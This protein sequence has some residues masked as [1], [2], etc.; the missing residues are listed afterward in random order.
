M[1]DPDEADRDDVLI[2]RQ[3]GGEGRLPRRLRAEVTPGAKHRA[4]RVDWKGKLGNP[5][6]SSDLVEPEREFGDNAE[7][8]A[9]AT[10]SPVKIGVLGLA[11]TDDVA[12]RRDHLECHNVVAGKSVLSGQPPHAAAEGEATDS[13]M[14]NVPGRRC[15]PMCLGRPVE[16][17]QQRATLNPCALLTRIDADLPHRG[18]I[19]HHPVIR[20][21]Q[22][23]HAM[24]T[25]THT[26]LE[27]K[28]ASGPNG[29]RHV[30]DSAAASDEAWS[31][32]DH[33]VPYRA[34]GV[35]A[36]ISRGEHFAIEGLRQAFS[37]H[38]ATPPRYMPDRDS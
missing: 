31:P 14:G 3:A 8:T 25:A 15:Q 4:G 22:A 17:T 2:A 20:N 11:R 19:D 18:Q 24:P 33:G 5:R 37:D 34:R 23:D 6:G 35:I 27:P 32:V 9:T 26:D 38:R 1:A 30:G 36:R 10:Q 29:C 16:R 7:V 21:P 13:R 28:I 12:V